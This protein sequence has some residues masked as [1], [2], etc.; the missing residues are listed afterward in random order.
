MRTIWLLDAFF[1]L[2][3]RIMARRTYDQADEHRMLAIEDFGGR[4][5]MD[6]SMQA[7]NIQVTMDIILQ[8]KKNSV[9]RNINY[10]NCFDRMAHSILSLK[11]RQLGHQKGPVICRLAT[12]EQLEVAIRTAFGDTPI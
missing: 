12:V 5:G 11:L 6:A 10:T 9:I 3:Q 8:K 7:V 2:T 1:S 4:K